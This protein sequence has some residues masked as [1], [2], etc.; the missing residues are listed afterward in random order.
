MSEPKNHHFVPQFY[1]RN[2]SAN[3]KQI[4]LYNFSGDR[5]VT[6]ASVSG[7]CYRRKL[8][9]FEPGLE[10]RL[11]DMETMASIVIRSVMDEQALPTPHTQ[12]WLDLLIFLIFQKARTTRSIKSVDTMNK[13]LREQVEQ[14]SE[15][16]PEGFIKELMEDQTPPLK[17]I[18]NTLPQMALVATDLQMHLLIN[19]TAEQFITCDD[20][21]VFH[22]M[23]CEGI[24]YRGVLGWDCRG[25]QAFFPLSPKHLLMLYDADT[26][27]VTGDQGLRHTSTLKDVRDV[28]CFN[29]FQ[30]LNAYENLYF[31]DDLSAEFEAFCRDSR[32]RRTQGRTTLVSSKMT[33]NADGTMSQIVHSYEPLLPIRLTPNFIKIRRASNSVPL[34]KRGALYRHR[35]PRNAHPRIGSYVRYE[36]DDIKHR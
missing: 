33:K 1:L 19:D 8:H 9:A 24:T 34:H 31:I 16:E 6:E 27:R 36:V 4:K 17:I 12:E 22:N 7:Q 23:Y 35:L 29:T 20:P 18:F 10:K 3:K 32:A 5:F 2:F 13:F 25:L 15:E 26:Y 14:G 11:G 30:A 21:V 28:R